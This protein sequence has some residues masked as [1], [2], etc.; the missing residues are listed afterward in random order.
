[1]SKLVARS[2]V[3]QLIEIPRKGDLRG[4]TDPTPKF[5]DGFARQFREFDTTSAAQC[6]VEPGLRPPS[7]EKREYFRQFRC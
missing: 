3:N 5:I 6:T 7:P 1:V 4:L 2:S